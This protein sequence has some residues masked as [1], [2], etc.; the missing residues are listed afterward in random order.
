MYKNPWIT[1]R[2]DEI[3]RPD[4][5]D[6]IYGVVSLHPSVIIIA[7]DENNNVLLVNQYRYTLKRES[8]E[9]P[10][11]GSDGQDPLEAAKRELWEETGFIASSWKQIGDLDVHNGVCDQKMCIFLAT[12][13]TQTG[14]HE[15][16][17]DG[18]TDVMQ[19]PY[20]D[21]MTM[22]KQGK[23]RDTEVLSALLLAQ[24]YV[25]KT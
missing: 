15:K 2:E 16:E 21:V 9:L 7:L 1:V 12:E 4:G 10:A 14:H 5:S 22:V 23:I 20:S 13:L 3:V 11:G 8:I 24:P 25:T 17:D 19:V 6:G 18:I